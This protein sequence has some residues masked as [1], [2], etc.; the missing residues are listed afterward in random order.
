M[1][2][3]LKVAM[4]GGGRMG[5]ALVQGALNAGVCSRTTLT[6]G[7]PIA[8]RRRVLAQR[9]R[10]RVTADNQQA[11]ENADV[12]VLAIKPQELASVCDEVRGALMARQCV[13]SIAAGVSIAWLRRHLKPS[14]RLVRVMPNLAATVGSAISAMSCAAGATALDRRRAKRLFEAVGSVVEVRESALN[15]VTAVSGSGPAYFAWLTEAMSTAGMKIGL[16]KVVAH[17][18]ALATLQGSAALLA[19]G[20]VSPSELIQQV[21]SKGGTTEAAMA[22]L[23]ASGSARHVHRAIRAAEQRARTLAQRGK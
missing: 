20:E 1:A 22:S 19:T 2:A 3:K 13:I 9:Y 18:L 5:A 17:Q 14:R 21:S 12:V 6:I 10:V 8:R 7:E 23:R 15:A 11:V 4:L 16:S